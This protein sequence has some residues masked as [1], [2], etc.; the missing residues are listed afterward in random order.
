MKLEEK[1]LAIKIYRDL[2][3][4]LKLVEESNEFN[5]QQDKILNDKLAIDSEKMD[6]L[7]E[8]KE[9]AAQQDVLDWIKDH[10]NEY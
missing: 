8:G 5:N 7:I 10:E 1:I 3:K 2:E 4:G 9:L 6:Q